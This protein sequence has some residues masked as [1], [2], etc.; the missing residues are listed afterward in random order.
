MDADPHI[1]HVIVTR[2]ALRFARRDERSLHA[3]LPAILALTICL[4]AVLI[5][6]LLTQVQI[7]LVTEP[8]S[9][10][11][12]APVSSALPLSCRRLQGRVTECTAG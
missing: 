8:A 3:L 9:L 5:D 12:L 10:I 4:L 2:F 1:E 7:T 11:V 6:P